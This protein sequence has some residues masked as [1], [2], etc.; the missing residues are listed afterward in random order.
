MVAVGWWDGSCEMGVGVLVLGWWWTGWWVGG[1]DM[2]GCGMAAVLV[3]L[4]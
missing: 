4:Q 3:V 1:S 2:V